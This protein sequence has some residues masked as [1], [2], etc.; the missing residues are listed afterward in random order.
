VK[1]YLSSAVNYVLRSRPFDVTVFLTSSCNFRCGHCFYWKKL[2]N[3][4]ELSLDEFISVARS[5]PRLERLQFTGG[6][7]FLRKD[8]DL[9][10]GEFYKQSRPM[11]ITIPT[12]GYFTDSIVEKTESIVKNV[13]ECFVNI[14]LQLNDIGTRRDEAVKV[15][16]SFEHLVDTAKELNRLKSKLPNWE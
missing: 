12:N 15:K 8:I 14:S 16:G 9:I 2:N 13:P 10:V 6:E 11:Y 3:N 7:P 4:E 5:M 1:H